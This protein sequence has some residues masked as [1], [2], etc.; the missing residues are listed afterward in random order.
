MKAVEVSGM[1]D[2]SLGRVYPWTTPIGCDDKDIAWI[3]KNSEFATS[4]RVRYS[5]G[6]TCVFK[7]KTQ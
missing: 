4:I 5:N 6:Q 1:G 2:G 7:R 3:M